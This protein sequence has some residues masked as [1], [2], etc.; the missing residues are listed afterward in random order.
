VLAR[1]RA[2]IRPEA[3]RLRAEAVLTRGCRIARCCALAL[4]DV[5]QIGAREA[6]LTLPV[7]DARTAERVRV[8]R[9]PRLDVAHGAE[10]DQ[11]ARQKQPTTHGV[12][13][14]RVRHPSARLGRTCR[15]RR[16]RA[17][18]PVSSEYRRDGGLHVADNT[19][20]IAHRA[21]VNARSPREGAIH[22][23]EP[24]SGEAQ[25]SRVLGQLA[26]HVEKLPATLV[27]EPALTRG[28]VR[29]VPRTLTTGEP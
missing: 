19:L 23:R 14:E 25:P 5:R 9:T 17:E 8:G 26:Q 24:R 2:D 12:P 16:K 11:T 27:V 7:A 28:I 22:D 29:E 15:A 20:H 1:A 13:S 4:H 3:N 6:E 21:Q 10:H 18:I